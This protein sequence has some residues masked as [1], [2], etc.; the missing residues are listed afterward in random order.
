MRDII[1][2]LPNF[3]KFNAY[4]EDVKKYVTP[5][6]L[7][8][9]NDSG[10]VHFAYSTHFY[11]ERPICIVTYNELQ[12]KKIMKDLQYFTND[13]CYFPKREIITYDYLTESKENSYSRI[14]TLNKIHNGQAKV[15][16]TTIEA[17]TQKIIHEEDLYK[18]YIKLKAN[19]TINLEEVKEKLVKLGYERCDIVD[20]KG[21]FSVRG[22]IVDIAISENLGIRMEL[23][24]DE[25]DSIRYFDIFSQ[26]STDKCDD[27][28]IYPA[29]EFVLTRDISEIIKDIKK[30]GKN[31]TEEYVE[32]ENLTSIDDSVWPAEGRELTDNYGNTY[33]RAVSGVRYFPLRVKP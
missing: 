18:N 9:M 22:G 20:T 27:I 16:V 4:I 24:G 21:Q 13:V 25:I 30:A 17:V 5:I 1:K 14:S 23:W 32:M 2:V 7:S 15:V 12:A 31:I 33:Q 10:K 11:V 3:K 29:H 26:R 19:E 28:T 6:M 8:G